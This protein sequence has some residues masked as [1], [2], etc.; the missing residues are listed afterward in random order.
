MSQTTAEALAA[1]VDKVVAHL[2][3]RGP[4]PTAD[5]ISAANQQLDQAQRDGTTPADVRKHRR[6]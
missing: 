4:R 5:E 1:S 3:G 2:T 6:T